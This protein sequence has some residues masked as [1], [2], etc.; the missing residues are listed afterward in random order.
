MPDY[1]NTLSFTVICQE[2]LTTLDYRVL[3]KTK[4]LNALK[5]KTQTYQQRLDELKTEY[6]RMKPKSSSE[7]QSAD[8][9][10]RKKEEDAMVVTNVI[11][12]V[13]ILRFC[14]LLIQYADIVNDDVCVCLQN[15]RM[16]ENSL[17][18][19]QFKCKEAENIMTSY[20]KLKSHLQV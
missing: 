17:E 4:R 15:L 19:T 13:K 18:K 5:H 8:A 12:S 2:A 9:H 14:S 16:L 3:S 10:A 6:Q 7:R 11:V 20:L 1:M